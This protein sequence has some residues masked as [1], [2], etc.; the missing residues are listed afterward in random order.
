MLTHN[1]AKLL[2]T[3]CFYYDA[4]NA[5]VNAEG[6]VSKTVDEFADGTVANL[7]GDG[8]RTRQALSGICY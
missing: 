1:M 7:L 2:C 4:N 5:T 8:F 3:S 6:A